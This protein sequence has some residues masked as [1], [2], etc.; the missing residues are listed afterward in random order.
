MKH[1]PTPP[2]DVILLQTL[3]RETEPMTTM[4][5]AQM[6]GEEPFKVHDWLCKFVKLGLVDRGSN[7]E[8]A[9]V[10]LPRRVAA[11]KY[12]SSRS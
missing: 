10:W 11:E 2:I 7:D 4:D 6:W 3:V 5:L 1:K 8:A 12:I 9:L